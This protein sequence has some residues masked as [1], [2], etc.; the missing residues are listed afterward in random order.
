MMR[1][2]SSGFYGSGFNTGISLL[3]LLVISSLVFGDSSDAESA[4][5]FSSIHPDGEIF[6]SSYPQEVE[7]PVITGLEAI[8]F[9]DSFL[10]HMG[11]RNVVFCRTTWI[12]AP[13]GG[14]LVDGLCEIDIEGTHYTS[15]R[16]GIGDGS[17]GNPEE[18]KFTFI[19][20]GTADGNGNIHWHPEPGPDFQPDEDEIIPESCLNYEFLLNREDFENLEIDFP[21]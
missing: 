6:D 2:H 7:F 11:A 20:H 4:A 5:Y 3:L 1:T 10:S 8:V 21:R 18:D 15:F 14:Y 12:V 19:A 9:A 17:E 16:I 13:L